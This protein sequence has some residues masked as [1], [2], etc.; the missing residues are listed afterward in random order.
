MRISWAHAEARKEFHLSSSCWT[1]KFNWRAER[2]IT[3][4]FQDLYYWMKLLREEIYDAGGSEGIG[5]KPKH[6]RQKQIQLYWYCKEGRNS[7]P[8]YNFTQKNV[9]MK[10][11]QESSSPKFH[12]R[13]K[14]ALVVSSRGTA[15]LW[16]K[17]LQLNPKIRGVRD[18]LKC[19]LGKKEVCSPNVVLI[20]ELRESRVTWFRRLWR[21]VFQRHMPRETEKHK[22]K[23]FHPKQRW[24][25]M[26]KVRERNLKCENYENF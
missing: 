18:T 5:E 16:D 17:I 21:F 9:P 11:S 12:W 4:Y 2:R 26:K 19:E 3:V 1:E 7:E 24:F 20:S 6:L 8:Y 22:Q 23:I 13:W 25:Q 15:Y 14:Q 10:R